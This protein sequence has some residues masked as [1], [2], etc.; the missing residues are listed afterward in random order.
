MRWHLAETSPGH[1]DWSNFLPMLCAANMLGMQV[2]WDLCHYGWPDDIDIWS[3]EFVERFAQFARAVACVVRDEGTSRPL[4]CPMNEMSYWAW[5][6]AEVGRI[7]PVVCGRGA[8][9]KRQLVRAS[10]A[11]IRAIREAD[12]SA[13][14]IVAEPLINVV[15][16]STEKD[17]RE[18][19]EIYRLAQFEVHDMLTGR[20]EP[21]L[22]GTLDCMDIVGVNF[23]PDNQWYL[24][25][26]TIPFGHHA[27]RP[28][29]HMLHEVFERYGRP[30]LIAETGAEGRAK[31]Y[32]LHH[33]CG[34]VRL[35]MQ[36]G[37]PVEGIC[38]YPILDYHG[39]DN[40]RVCQ[41][42]LLSLPDAADH[43]RICPHLENEL[44]HQ[45]QFFG[46]L[47]DLEAAEEEL[48]YG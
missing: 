15:A 42:G 30:V 46:D 23:Y 2:I 5:A 13:R 41:V 29:E 26:N 38:L 27:Y 32:W 31:S 22:G 43:R 45:Q 9:L 3:S 10:I 40:G 33:V 14:F 16:G 28:L 18:A 11:A 48:R 37:V 39:W 24:H 44:R 1:Y 19:A 4:Y 25:G 20:M 8:D 17:H 7:N 36:S 12:P 21:E 6:G 35:A 34:E 47:A